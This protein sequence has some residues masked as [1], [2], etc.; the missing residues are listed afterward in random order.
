LKGI[1]LQIACHWLYK[2]GFKY[3]AHK[4]RVILWWPWAW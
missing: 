3:M 1:S 2:E 4:K